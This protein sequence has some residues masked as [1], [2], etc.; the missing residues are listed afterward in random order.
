MNLEEATEMWI[1]FKDY[2]PS[3]DL[4]AAADQFISVISHL[5]IVDDG[6]LRSL[7]ELDYH[8]EN[9]VSEMLNNQDEDLYDNN[10]DNVWD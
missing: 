5:G 7:A 9:V 6:D 1:T 4:Q 2:I 8:I 3:K 10:D